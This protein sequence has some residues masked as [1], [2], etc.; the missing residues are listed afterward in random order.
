L[1]DAHLAVFERLLLMQIVLA[2]DFTGIKLE[3][4]AGRSSLFAFVNK[5]WCTATRN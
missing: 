3:V 1:R 5:L 2:I 4:V